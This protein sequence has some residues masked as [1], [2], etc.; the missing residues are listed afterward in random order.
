MNGPSCTQVRVN[1]PCSETRTLEPVRGSVEASN[2]WTVN[3][4]NL[5][6]YQFPPVTTILLS[7]MNR[8]YKIEDTHC[9]LTLLDLALQFQQTALEAVIIHLPPACFHW[10]I[11]SLLLGQP[12]RELFNT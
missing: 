3:A 7:S 8:L 1:V 5:E 9:L 10:W 6:V 11:P 4:L 2:L 12:I